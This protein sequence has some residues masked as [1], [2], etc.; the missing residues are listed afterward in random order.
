MSHDYHTTSEEPIDLLRDDENSGETFWFLGSILILIGAS[1][2]GPIVSLHLVSNFRNLEQKALPSVKP[3]G[4]NGFNF[5]DLNCLFLK[6][7]V[8]N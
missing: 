8:I 1:G 3:L 7:G 2:F 6:F 5:N 4:S